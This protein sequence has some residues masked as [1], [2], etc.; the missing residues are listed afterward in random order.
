MPSVTVVECELKL[1]QP[2]VLG[3]PTAA[4]VAHLAS[5]WTGA[6]EWLSTRRLYSTGDTPWYWSVTQSELDDPKMRP[7]RQAFLDRDGNAHD[8]RAE[9]LAA[10]TPD[11]P[12]AP[13]PR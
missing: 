4:E 1:P 3:Y 12:A 6:M 2:D 5:S 8:T 10:W 9:A 11:A 13:G 7:T